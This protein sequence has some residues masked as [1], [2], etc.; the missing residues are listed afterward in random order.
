M[1]E[2]AIENQ[3]PFERYI[4]IDRLTKQLKKEKDKLDKEDKDGTDL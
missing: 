4:Y 2:Q 1:S 3:I